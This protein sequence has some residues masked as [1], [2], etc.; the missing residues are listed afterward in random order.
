MSVTWTKSK[1][2]FSIIYPPNQT[3]R[4]RKIKGTLNHFTLKPI[5]LEEGEVLCSLCHGEG[6]VWRVTTKVI[7]NQENVKCKKCWGEGKLDWLENITGK[8]NREEE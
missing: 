4:K 8:K 1:K 6:V 2:K 3:F 7:R 5:V